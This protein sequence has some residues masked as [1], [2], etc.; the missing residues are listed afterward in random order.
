MK[1]Y[2]ETKMTKSW[3]DKNHFNELAGFYLNKSV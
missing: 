1:G 3:N 2:L